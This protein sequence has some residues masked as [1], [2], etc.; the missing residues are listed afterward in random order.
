MP[1]CVLCQ[2]LFKSKRLLT[3][4]N[5]SQVPS[6]GA[7]KR[8]HTSSIANISQLI[9]CPLCSTRPFNDKTTLTKH[10]RSDHKGA[11]LDSD[12]L[13]RLRIT[14]FPQ[15]NQIFS[16]LKSHVPGKA[17][18]CIPID[19][20]KK[21]TLASLDPTTFFPSPNRSSQNI[22]SST[23][24]IPISQ[25][26]NT[27]IPY[28]DNKDVNDTADTLAIPDSQRSK[29]QPEVCEEDDACTI[30]IPESQLTP[31]LSSIT[32]F[33]VSHLDMN[34]T[35]DSNIVPELNLASLES[36]HQPS[37]SSLFPEDI[38]LSHCGG[39]CPRYCSFT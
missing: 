26:S 24:T 25:S 7:I 23:T 5:C 28:Y 1:T 13:S 15:C 35:L 8:K 21:S 22:I 37:F 34:S 12:T 9:E 11:Q 30:A 6:I 19:D 32:S 4:H 2:Q 3:K 36:A 17:K 20:T 16:S 29:T 39:T 14:S 18:S 27:T 31:S 10:L 33:P 38:P